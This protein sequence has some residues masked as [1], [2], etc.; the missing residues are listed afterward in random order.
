[1][2]LP[3][4]FYKIVFTYRGLRKDI[5]LSLLFPLFFQSSC[6]FDADLLIVLGEGSYC[7]YT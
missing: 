4:V 7:N 6:N 3:Q 2:S 5:V 1:M